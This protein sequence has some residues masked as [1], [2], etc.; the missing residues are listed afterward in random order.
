M[1]RRTQTQTLVVGNDAGKTIT[2]SLAEFAQLPRTT[3][4]VKAPHS[5]EMVQYEGVLLYELLQK[6][7]V[8]FV[9]RST[10]K[11]MERKLPG[12]LRTSYVLIEAADGY[13]IVYS[14]AEIHPDLGGRRV[15]LADRQNGQ[16][17]DAK[18]APFQV[19]NAASELHGRWIR[20]VTRILVQPAAR[21]A[22]EGLTLSREALSIGNETGKTIRLTPAEFAQLP[23]TVIQDKVPHH[24]DLTASYEG[25]LLHELLRKA[26]VQ[27]EDPRV[28]RR[29]NGECLRPS[30]PLTCSW[31]QP[32]ATRWS[33]RYPRFIPIWE[34]G[35]CSWPIASTANRLRTTLDHTE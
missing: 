25:V 30:A 32:T 24:D 29:V 1:S 10:P 13:R 4:Q 14:V 6:A 16:P 11:T 31:R 35:E 5:E 23:R 27:F 26:G 21:R 17:L 9:D 20:Q 19:I 2:L 33:S 18:A 15:L 3:L 22:V 12:T 7:G 8:R 34:V 28:P